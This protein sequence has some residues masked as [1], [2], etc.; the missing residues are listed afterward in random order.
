LIK[1]EANVWIMTASGP[2]VLSQSIEEKH[3]EF[4]DRIKERTGACSLRDG[5]I[6]PTPERWDFGAS[7]SVTRYMSKEVRKFGLSYGSRSTIA[8]P[9]RDVFNLA[10][11]LNR[12]DPKVIVDDVFMFYVK[13]FRA[14]DAS[15]WDD[16]LGSWSFTA[17]HEMIR[18]AVRFFLIRQI[19]WIS[20]EYAWE[21]LQISS[22]EIG[23]QVAPVAERV[24]YFPDGVYIVLDS[25]PLT[26][27][28]AK[29]KTLAANLALY[30]EIAPIIPALLAIDA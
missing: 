14:S 8:Q 11:R 7:G 6:P 20:N 21:H 13:A 4:F 9:E 18:L 30:P 22:R 15:C 29:E 12:L 19:N 2:V 16:R 23:E 17:F 1:K 24:E 27:A 3:T 5:I 25:R 10:I 26:M 28:E